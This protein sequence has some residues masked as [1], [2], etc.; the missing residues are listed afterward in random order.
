MRMALKQ[1]DRA[2]AITQKLS[3]FAKPIKEAVTQSVSVG[4]EV[5]EVLLLVGHDLKLEKITVEKEI[6]S[7]LPQIIA[8]R[9]QFQEVLFNL[10]RNAGQAIEP[11]GTI[12]VRAHREGEQRV[13]I[14]ITDT[15]SG[16]PA[17][18]MEKIWD[19]FFTTKPVGQGTGLGL[20]VSHETCKS[21][22]ARSRCSPR[23]AR[24]Q[25]SR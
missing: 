25:P 24:E 8:D 2:T 15:G 7:D 9:R 21:T 5:D 18:K 16:I 20:S 22:A 11:P 19:P 1:I 4:Q 14:E 3:N 6:Q 12:W 23:W 13:R 10:I 17:D